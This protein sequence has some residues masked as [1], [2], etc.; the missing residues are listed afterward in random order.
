MFLIFPDG[1]PLI[2]A[3]QIKILHKRQVVS[4]NIIHFVIALNHGAFKE[5]FRIDFSTRKQTY[6]YNLMMIGKHILPIEI[7]KSKNYLNI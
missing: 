1:F 4:V 3:F 5:N 2:R 6:V 7:V